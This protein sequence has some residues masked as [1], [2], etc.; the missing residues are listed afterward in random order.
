MPLTS[1]GS[2]LVVDASILVEYIVEGSPYLGR[3]EALFNPR[4]SN[5]QLFTVPQALSEAL[6]AISRIYELA[7][8]QDSNVRALEYIIWVQD[9]MKLKDVADLAVSAGE[10]RKELRLSLTDCYVIAAA[11]AIGGKALFLRPEKE[12]Q[13]RLNKL[14]E[15]N[16]IFL[17]EVEFKI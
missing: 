2:K 9:R 16:V 14:K 3:I 15:H 6:Y 4:S 8:L 12:M 17:E 13:A 5:L 7:G 11:K 10:L 1:R